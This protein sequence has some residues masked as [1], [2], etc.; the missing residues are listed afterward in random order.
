MNYVK[1][2]YRFL[3]AAISFILFSGMAGAQVKASYLYNLSNFTGVIPFT[4]VR[5]VPDSA[6]NEVYVAEGGSVYVFNDTG[7]EIYRFGDY[8]QLGSVLDVAVLESGDLLLLG[9]NA[10]GSGM[11]LF[12]CDYRGEIQSRL[13]LT[14]LPNEWGGFR[15]TKMTLRGEKLYLVDYTAK[16]VAVLDKESGSL[17]ETIDLAAKLETSKVLETG[18]K[19]VV[20][21]GIS[22]FDAD[23]ADNIFFT[24]NTHFK[25]YRLSA[26][27]KVESFGQPGGAPGKFGVVAG[28]AADRSGNIYV[29]DTLKCVVMVYNSDFEFLEEFGYRTDAP[30]GLVAPKEVSVSGSGKIYVT[31]QAN[32]GVNVY[33]LSSN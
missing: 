32:R 14:G 10:D 18:K 3:L 23:D 4:W 20:D 2:C 24:I 7:M 31:Q 16:K 9:T 13:R 6:Q 8:E 12:R 27:R 22:G 11:S 28:I 15:P 33:R 21:S 5:V 25:A 17:R 19:V 26:D 1:Y 29:V 30:G